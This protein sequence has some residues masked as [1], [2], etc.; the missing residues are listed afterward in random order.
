MRELQKKHE[1]GIAFTVFVAVW[2]SLLHQSGALKKT[3][4]SHG[5]NNNKNKSALLKNFFNFF[6]DTPTTSAKT[7]TDSSLH[8]FL[9][10]LPLICTVV[11]GVYS[12]VYIVHSVIFFPTCPKSGGNVKEGHETNAERVSQTRRFY[13]ET[14]A[15]DE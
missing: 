10:C 13:S 14:D 12:L 4:S 2:V 8:V 6:D 7:T 11:F 9:W 1:G 3:L 5:N 15:R